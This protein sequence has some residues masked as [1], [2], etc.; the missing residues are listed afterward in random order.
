MTISHDGS[1]LLTRHDVARGFGVKIPTSVN[2]IHD[3]H[4][5]GSLWL[6]IVC[7]N[8]HL[9]LSGERVGTLALNG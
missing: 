2:L 9:C 6:N 4:H 5:W 1:P 7:L 8:G 3:N